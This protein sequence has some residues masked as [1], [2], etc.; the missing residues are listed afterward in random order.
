[1]SLTRKKP[2]YLPKFD[3]T[4]S[5]EPIAELVKTMKEKMKENEINKGK[6]GWLN[7]HYSFLTY[8]LIEEVKELTDSIDDRKDKEH[9]KKEAA[10][11][12]NFAM[13]IHDKANQER[14]EQK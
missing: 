1:M 9:I 11:V 8:R 3:T 5:D 12:A 6:R 14:K 7:C 13:M 4:E 10:D 2:D